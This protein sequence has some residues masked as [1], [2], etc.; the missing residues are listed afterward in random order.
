MKRIVEALNI[1]PDSSPGEL[2]DNVHRA[3]DAFVGGAEQFDDLTM[4]CIEYKG[5]G[6][7]EA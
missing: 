1:A 3:V 4:L 5:P 6:K 2:L 7:T